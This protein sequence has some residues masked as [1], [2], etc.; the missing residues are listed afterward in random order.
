MRSRLNPVAVAANLYRYAYLIRQLRKADR[1]LA[2]SRF[3]RD[4]FA[5]NG[6]P[7]ERITPI[8]FGMPPVSFDQFGP[9]QPRRRDEPLRVGFLG[10]LMPDKGV[11]VLIDAFNRLPAGAAELHVFG[12]AFDPPYHE[13]LLRLARHPGIRWRGE[14]PHADRWRALGEIDVLVVPSVWYENSPLTIH[15]ARLAKVPVVASAIGGIPELVQHGVTGA[16]FP[17]GD[18][19]A[20]AACLQ[21]IIA[22]RSRLDAWRRAIPAPKTLDTHAGEIDA[23]YREL[24]GARAG[25]AQPAAPAP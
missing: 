18:A 8:E 3:L 4:V 12:G 24:H 25:G 17:A 1:I 7:A 23:L 14:L 22:D 11:H 13:E 21:A 16:T 6:I 9:A 10:S 19:A 5:R 2:P 20:L 15:E